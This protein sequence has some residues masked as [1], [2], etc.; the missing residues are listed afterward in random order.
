M[1]SKEIVDTKVVDGSLGNLPQMSS[2]SSHRE[3]P[4]FRIIS[5]DISALFKILEKI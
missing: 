3:R 2:E 1:I 5:A 4:R